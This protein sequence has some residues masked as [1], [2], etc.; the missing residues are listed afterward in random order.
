MSLLKPIPWCLVLFGFCFSIALVWLPQEWPFVVLV[1]SLAT[2]LFLLAW[3]ARVEQI[4]LSW[5]PLLL[6][7]FAVAAL[8][9]VQ[10]WADSTID[11]WQTRRAALEWA[12][13]GLA[14]AVGFQLFSQPLHRIR[15]LQ[16]FVFFSSIL[17]ILA[18]A[19]NYATPGK[20][21][22]FFDSG[23]PDQVFGPFVYHTKFANFVE[24]ALAPALWLT[25]TSAGN[26]AAYGAAS[27]VLMVSVAAS[28]S[29]GGTL[30][31]ALELLVLLFLY[32]R[33]VHYSPPPGFFRFS[34]F[35]FSAIVLAW[36]VLGGSAISDRFN[37]SDALLDSRWAIFA[38]SLD[39]AKAYFWTGSGLGTWST[40]YPEFARFDNGL[41]INQ[42]HCDWI[43]WLIEGGVMMLVLALSIFLTS[44][45]LA[46]THWWAFGFVF[47]WIH[48]SI[49]YPMQQTPALAALY[50]AFWG[51]ALRASL[52]NPLLD[53]PY[54]QLR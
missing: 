9:T 20:V 30:V 15:F 16:G 25:M 5:H 36:F 14:A 12:S 53:D 19:Q 45:R 48:G 37:S 44:I 34:F 32:L 38:S 3:I 46:F 24:L 31:L 54:S 8:A 2:A 35:F 49:D 39:M 41:R 6:L 11:A 21:W 4:L 50:F 18:V 13:F 23:F 51:I 43:Q 52:P 17:V 1:I 27:A 7:P 40:L 33:S 29:R 28:S 10:F 42:A 22:F 47:V 26:R